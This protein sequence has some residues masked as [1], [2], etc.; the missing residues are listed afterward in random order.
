MRIY[1]HGT[2]KVYAIRIILIWSKYQYVIIRNLFKRMYEEFI[3]IFLLVGDGLLLSTDWCGLIMECCWDL[4]IW[5]QLWNNFKWMW[6]YN[7]SLFKVFFCIFVF[8]VQNMTFWSSYVFFEQQSNVIRK[9][10][11]VHNSDFVYAL[12][13]FRLRTEFGSSLSICVRKSDIVLL[14]FFLNFC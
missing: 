8:Y 11:I 5:Q 2:L 3:Y 9:L 1:M 10:W 14:L 7:I 12:Y 13:L 4:L 6:P